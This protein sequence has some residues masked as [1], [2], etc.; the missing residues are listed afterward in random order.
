MD[1]EFIEFFVDL[2][3]FVGSEMRK[4][5]EKFEKI[6]KSNFWGFMLLNI[7]LMR[8]VYFILLM[9]GEGGVKNSSNL[10]CWWV[11]IVKYWI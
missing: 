4:Y 9:V 2:F 3:F 7:I 1:N 8:Y 6:V 11:K 5:C 10:L